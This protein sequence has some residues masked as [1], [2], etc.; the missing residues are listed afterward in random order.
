MLPL[1]A[2]RLSGGPWSLSPSVCA[3]R[4]S[5]DSPSCS[6]GLSFRRTSPVQSNRPNR[7]KTQEPAIWHCPS[8]SSA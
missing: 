7:L 6:C 2:L 8:Y 1:M 3:G 5:A 4:R